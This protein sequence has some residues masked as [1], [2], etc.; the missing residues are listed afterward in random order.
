M[1][2]RAAAISIAL[3]TTL[4]VAAAPPVHKLKLTTGTNHLDVAKATGGGTVLLVGYEQRLRGYSQAFRR[5][6]RKAKA[7]TDVRKTVGMNLGALI[8]RSWLVGLTILAVGLLG[9]REDGLTAAILVLAAFTIY[10]A[11][12]LLSRSLEGN[13]PRS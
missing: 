9:D 5:V 1:H 13:P 2:I 6:E 12:S 11:T 3:A 10:F 8:A 4:S 7:A